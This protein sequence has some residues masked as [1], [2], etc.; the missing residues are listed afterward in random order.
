MTKE[1]IKHSSKNGKMSQ[2][3]II[4]ININTEKKAKANT[5]TKKGK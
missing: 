1:E 3:Q 4:K 5:K 2:T